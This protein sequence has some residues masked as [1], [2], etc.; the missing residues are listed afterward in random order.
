MVNR[1]GV[2]MEVITDNGGYFVAADK[3]FKGL[4][5]DFTSENKVAF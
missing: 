1:R 5:S 2:P 3:E 4:V